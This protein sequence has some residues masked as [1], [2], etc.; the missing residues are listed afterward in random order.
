LWSYGFVEDRTHDGRRYRML[1]V[2]D[3]AKTAYIEPGADRFQI[4][5][6]VDF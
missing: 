6:R 4:P 1:N 5:A 3:G 2:I